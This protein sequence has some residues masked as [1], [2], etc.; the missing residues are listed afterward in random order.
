MNKEMLF[1]ALSEVGDDLIVMAEHKRFTSPWRKWGQTAAVL[2]VVVC[3]GVLAL[4][5]F[6]MGCGSSVETA[7][8][9]AQ[10]TE[11]LTADLEYAME[12]NEEVCEE[13]C[14]EEA[15]IEESDTIADARQ[16]AGAEPQEAEEG[17]QI[18][19]AEPL[20]KIIC[21][22]TYFYLM[23]EDFVTGVPPLGEELGTV[24]SYEDLSLAGCTVYTVPYS[25][26]FG[27]HAVNGQPVTQQ[28]YLRTISGYRYGFTYNEKIVSRYTMDDVRTAVNKENYDWLADT[29]VQPLEIAGG[30]QFTDVTELS[31]EELNTI[32][33]AS[34]AM[35][36]GVVVFDQWIDEKEGT[37]VVPISD[38]RWRLSRFLDEGYVYEPEKTGFYD[39]VRDAMVC[40]TEMVVYNKLNIT[41]HAAEILDENRLFLLISLPDQKG[42]TKEYIIRFDDDSWRYETINE[43]MPDGIAEEGP[44]P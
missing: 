37:Y 40:P 16:D 5:Y 44:L 42:V 8:S 13:E 27:N 21:R 3:L 4:P 29:F 39:E 35:N 2:A 32:F 14:I 41:V 25:A 12:E 22:G 24:E 11:S 10:V 18:L 6:P 26:W 30:V 34:T 31:S 28:I 36:T 7:E 43:I 23:P 9:T 1:E 15:A 17:G 20:T 19:R 33:L 38:V